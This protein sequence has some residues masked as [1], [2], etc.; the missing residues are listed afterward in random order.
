[1]SSIKLKHSG[2]NS[3]II[4]APSS[5]PAA[6][7]TITLP[8]LAA[9][10]VMATVN[11]ITEFDLWTLTANHSSDSG[12]D[13]NSNLSRF[14]ESSNNGAASQIGTGM[15]KDSNGIFTFPSTGKWVIFCTTSM[16]LDGDD[17]AGLGIMVSKNGASGSFSYNA[18][19][20]QGQASGNS[21]AHS[22]SNIAYID[23]TDTSNVKV[24]FSINSL[25]TNS[26][27]SGDSSYIR[28]CFAFIR[29]G[30]T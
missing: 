21:T 10:A 22:S 14:T 24:K 30:G 27:I 11:G 26:Y 7:R 15:T 3:V 23:V 9:N 5:N 17:N 18:L 4:A 29:I 19:T 16:Y 1:M 2:G 12:S 28:T 13:L 20:Y 25:G 6:D 8:D